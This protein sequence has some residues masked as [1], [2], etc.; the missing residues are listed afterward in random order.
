M[1]ITT[2]L[3][4]TFDYIP[5]GINIYVFN[6]YYKCLRPLVPV[7]GSMIRFQHTDKHSKT[8]MSFNIYEHK[9]Q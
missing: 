1:Q 8:L 7:F 9:H 6:T 2:Y 4:W 5:Y 3:L